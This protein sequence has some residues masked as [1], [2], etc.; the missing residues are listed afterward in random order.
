MQESISST[1]ALP[2][3][4]S[5]DVLTTI[6]RVGA[7]RMLAQ[8]IEAEVSEWIDDHAHLTDNRTLPKRSNG[9]SANRHQLLNPCPN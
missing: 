3:A 5:R 9:A 8:A 4:S 7:Q 2:A 1:I 6:L